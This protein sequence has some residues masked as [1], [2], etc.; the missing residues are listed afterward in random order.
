VFQ[1]KTLSLKKGNALKMRGTDKQQ[2]QRASQGHV[3][4]TNK[5][6]NQF[7]D[8]ESLILATKD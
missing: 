7:D 5:T 6:T 2:N 4:R 3:V 1:A 8:K